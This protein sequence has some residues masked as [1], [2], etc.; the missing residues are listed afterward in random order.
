MNNS[1]FKISEQILKE[2]D[3]LVEKSGVSKQDFLTSIA[4]LYNINSL[5]E[6]DII[7]PVAY[8]DSFTA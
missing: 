8:Y 1:T 7:D 6:K 3:G 2:F 5:S 4:K